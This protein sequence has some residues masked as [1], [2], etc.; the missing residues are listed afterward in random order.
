MND[1]KIR[2][3]TFVAYS[4]IILIN[5][6]FFIG[7]VLKV[8]TSFLTIIVLGILL[9]S[10]DYRKVTSILFIPLVFLLLS[11]VNS[12]AIGLLFLFLFCYAAK[13][14]KI[15]NIALLNVIMQ[16]LIL[17]CVYF[18]LKFNLIALNIAE[19]DIKSGYDLGMGNANTFSVFIFSIV[20][21]LYILFVK[22]SRVILPIILFVISLLAYYYSAC[23]TIFISEIVLLL[24]HFVICFGGKGKLA[25]YRRLLALMPVVLFLLLVYFSL[26]YETYWELNILLS[27]RLACYYQVFQNLSLKSLVLGLSIPEGTPFDSSI[28]IF[29]VYGGL[30]GALWFWMLFW[31]TITRNFWKVVNFCPVIIAALVGGISES[32]FA[33]VSIPGNVIMIMILYQNSKY[34]K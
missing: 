25:K 32:F 31:K 34:V 12:G 17:V 4:A 11:F 9:V 18:S 19:T 7:D 10:I 33:S 15:E 28:L 16:V 21:N 3:S 14:C 2:I 6:R 27:Q 8:G 30:L 5:L 24:I 13:D 1:L 20:C 29:Y 23:R 26:N 22:K